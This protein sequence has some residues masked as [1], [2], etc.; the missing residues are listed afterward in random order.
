MGK[1]LLQGIGVPLWAQ[2][3]QTGVIVHEDTSK[4]DVTTMFSSKNG[5]SRKTLYK[6]GCKIEHHR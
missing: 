1:R 6:G 3:V 5:E 2:R 4:E